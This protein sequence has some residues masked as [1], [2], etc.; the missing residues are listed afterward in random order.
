MILTH[1]FLLAVPPRPPFPLLSY[2]GHVQTATEEAG[3]DPMSAPLPAAAAM[4]HSPIRAP[5]TQDALMV[6]LGP[7]KM[8]V[9]LHIHRLITLEDR[10]FRPHKTSG[11]NGSRQGG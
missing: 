2:A 8:H 6:V 7:T 11:G 1:P 9:A 3:D 5:T 4:A 10:L